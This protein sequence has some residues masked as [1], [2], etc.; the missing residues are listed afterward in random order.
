MNNI[1]ILDSLV[2]STSSN[3]FHELFWGC[4]Q[5]Q[6]K[7]ELVFADFVVMWTV[8][9]WVNLKYHGDPRK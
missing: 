2:V 5:V 7:S 8:F 4:R 1:A 3:S 6:I 9:V